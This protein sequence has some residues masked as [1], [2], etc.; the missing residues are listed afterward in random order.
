MVSLN[1]LFLRDTD[2]CCIT[3]SEIMA[4][5]GLSHLCIS[6]TSHAAAFLTPIPKSEDDTQRRRSL[7]AIT[8]GTSTNDLCTSVRSVQ[9]ID[10]SNTFTF[11]EESVDLDIRER[12]GY[13]NIMRAVTGEGDIE[14]DLTIKISNYLEIF[15]RLT[16][17]REEVGFLVCCHQSMYRHGNNQFYRMLSDYMSD[18]MIHATVS[19]MSDEIIDHLCDRGEF[20][21]SIQRTFEEPN[22]KGSI[23]EIA[24]SILDEEAS[25]LLFVSRKK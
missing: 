5:D 21:E 18:E 24:A 15:E 22:M 10:D 19:V 2:F 16:P 9:N 4:C 6:F 23:L 1:K 11:T 12:Q 14:D 8:T 20:R 3:P 25:I 13:D 17:G 7:G